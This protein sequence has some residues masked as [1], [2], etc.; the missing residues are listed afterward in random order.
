MPSLSFMT[1]SIL[2]DSRIRRTGSRLLRSAVLLC[3]LALAACTSLPRTPYSAAEASGSR[4]LDIDGLRRYTDEPVTKF[5]FEK[6]DR[7]STRTYLALS[8]GGADGAYGV[9]VLNG[10]TAAGSRP[11][12]SVVS[13]VSTG[14]L[15]APFAFLGSQYDDTL[16][17]VYTSGIAESL[18]NDPSI[19]RVLFGSGLFG[20]K[21]LRELV[22]RYVGPEILAAVARENAKGRKLLVV[23]TDLDTQ[24]TVV[25]DMGKIAAIGSPEALRLFRDVMAASASIPLVFPPILIEAEGQGRRF[26]EMHVD[27]GVTAPVLTLPDALLFQGRLPGNSRM[28]IYILVN[29]KLE[30]TFELVSNSTIDVASRSLSSITQSQTRSVIFSTYDFAKRNRWGFHLSYIE[31]DYPASSSEGFDTAYMRALYQYGYEKAASGR[32]WTSTLP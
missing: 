21:R 18:L 7:S 16:R 28:N 25:W 2:S 19:I 30:R 11:A 15:I 31:R 13:G 23:T 3:S 24:R 1:G 6:D 9:G 14:G 26:E 12:F 17:E 5:R 27:G 32:A 4:V 29:K 20:N 10:W 8:G 22:A